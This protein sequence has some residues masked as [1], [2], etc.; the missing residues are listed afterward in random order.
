[1]DGKLGAFSSGRSS[2]GGVDT[3]VTLCFLGPRGMGTRRCLAVK[4]GMLGSTPYDPD[5]SM[6]FHRVGVMP[7]SITSTKVSQAKNVARC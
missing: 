2:E 5:G 7:Y 3:V 6:W 4:M 1:M